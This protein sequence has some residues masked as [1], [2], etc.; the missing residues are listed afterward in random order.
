MKKFRY[1]FHNLNLKKR[2]LMKKI[3]VLFLILTLMSSIVFAE[4]AQQKIQAIKNT[5]QVTLNGEKVVA[6]N[7][8]YEGL[9]YVQLKEISNMIDAN[10]T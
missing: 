2:C 1:T 4:Q 3:S 8:L 7:L 9:T 5:I 10:L 6:D